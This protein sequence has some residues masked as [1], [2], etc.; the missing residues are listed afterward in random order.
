MPCKKKNTANFRERGCGFYVYLVIVYSLSLLPSPPI[1]TIWKDIFCCV[2]VYNKISLKRARGDENERER[3]MHKTRKNLGRKEMHKKKIARRKYTHTHTQPAV[4]FN[5]LKG[6]LSAAFREPR[7]S[8]S[9][10]RDEL[11]VRS[12]YTSSLLFF[13]S[14]WIISTALRRLSPSVQQLHLKQSC[15]VLFL[16]FISIFHLFDSCRPEPQTR[17]VCHL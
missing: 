6:A 10:L 16:Y 9:Q 17:S 11:E 7:F 4:P 14:H 12:Y 1:L 13:F 2:K 3:E 15:S 5:T 8:F